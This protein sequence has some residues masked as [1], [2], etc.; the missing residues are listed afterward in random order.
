VWTVDAPG[1]RDFGFGA[2]DKFSV[3]QKTVDGVLV[4]SYYVQGSKGGGAEALD[5]GAEAIQLYDK[6][7]G[8]YPY[9]EFSVVEADFYIG[10]ME[11]PGMVL[12]D[13]S[14]YGA[15]SVPDQTMLDLVVAHETSHQWWYSTIGDDEVMEP[16]LDEGMA[17]FSTQYFFEKERNAAFNSYYAQYNAYL[18]SMRKE[19]AG[20]YT[21]TLPV[22]RYPDNETYSAWVYVRT[23]EVLQDL[24]KKMGDNAFFSALQ[25]YYGGNR[26]GIT[27]RADFEKAFDTASGTD[28]SQWFEQ[29]FNSSG[30]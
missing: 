22:F 27:T 16:W 17:E 2:S 18:K 6:T 13:D 11:Y 24:R 26:L 12:I 29:E 1:R 23:S 9:S 15:S 30:N 7:F 19:Q 25:G 10:G 3:M 20:E 8:Q 5:T 4:R 21:P 14:L 28:L